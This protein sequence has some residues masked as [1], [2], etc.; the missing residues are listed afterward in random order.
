M[1]L[2]KRN[3][4]GIRLRSDG[5]PLSFSIDIR[6]FDNNVRLLHLVAS[7]WQAVGVKTEVKSMARQ[8]FQQRKIAMVFDFAV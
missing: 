1:G 5:E 8:L 4:E 6:G 7:D 3:T 2:E